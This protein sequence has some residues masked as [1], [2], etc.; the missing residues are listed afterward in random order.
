MVGER[1][2]KKRGYIYIYREREREGEMRR[3]GLRGTKIHNLLSVCM[4]LS[5][6]HMTIIY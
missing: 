4:F 5:L 6:R 1:S 2:R 3:R